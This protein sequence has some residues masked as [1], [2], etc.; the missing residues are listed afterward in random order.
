MFVFP[1][2]TKWDRLHNYLHVPEKTKTKTKTHLDS[3]RAYFFPLLRGGVKDGS[4]RAYFEIS[5]QQKSTT[6]RTLGS[7]LLR[8]GLKNEKKERGKGNDLVC[9]PHERTV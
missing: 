4:Y 1:H 2:E 8:Q 3:F 5:Y 7:E 6:N 9:Y